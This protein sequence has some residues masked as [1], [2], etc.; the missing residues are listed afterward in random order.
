MQRFIRRPITE[1]HHTHLR[2]EV[3]ISLQNWA[4]LDHKNTATTGHNYGTLLPDSS[5]GYGHVLL[6]L[7]DISWSIWQKTSEQM[8]VLKTQFSNYQ[9][10][11]QFKRSVN[12]H[13][14][15]TK[16]YI[17]LKLKMIVLCICKSQTHL[18]SLRLSD[19]K[20]TIIGSDN[21]LS[22]G[23]GQA[24]IWTN[25]GILLIGPLGTNFSEISIKV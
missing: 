18:K 15:I 21:G 1:T 24:I 4:S 10:T 19:A 8:S 5:I 9:K 17:L 11:F 6:W 22:P 12:C 7:L 16:V 3:L 13:M 23:Q 2:W 25:A 14:Y 20:L